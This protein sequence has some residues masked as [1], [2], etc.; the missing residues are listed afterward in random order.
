MPINCKYGSSAIPCS[1]YLQSPMQPPLLHNLHGQKLWLSGERCIFWEEASA[2]I[3]SDCH[4]GKTGHFRK[5]GIA[6]PQNIYKE[7]LQRLV[8]VLNFFKPAQLIIVGDLFHSRANLELDWFKKWR[9]NFSDT[10]FILV[11]GNHDILA[12]QWYE[13][14]GIEIVKDRLKIGSFV[15]SHE[16]CEKEEEEFVFC[17]HIHPG[18]L[19]NGMG[20]QSLRL[21]CFYFTSEHCILPAFSR[22]TG[23]A[24]IN[25]EGGDHVY[26]VAV[27]K[28]VKIQ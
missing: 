3:V 18:I 1:L 13:D 6:V 28:L 4:F 21:P 15:F 17:G 14:A 16:H 7:D 25:P 5:Y 24:N 8:A 19:L 2:L 22:F 26:A 23:L 10:R 11:M 27:N 20:K 9:K 12:K